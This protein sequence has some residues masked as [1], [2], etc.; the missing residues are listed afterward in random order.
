MGLATPNSELDHAA[1]LD[2]VEALPKP[3]HGRA[4]PPERRC[5]AREI[6]Q[7]LAEHGFLAEKE[8]EE[9]TKGMGASHALHEKFR[10]PDQAIWYLSG[11]ILPNST[12]I[13]GLFFLYDKTSAS[14]ITAELKGN[15]R[16]SLWFCGHE[17]T[18][19]TIPLPPPQLDPKFLWVTVERLFSEML[20]TIGI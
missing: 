12:Q 16:V 11:L 7:L 10:G 3:D 2:L 18:R 14:Q 8:L 15:P 20:S 5:S 4:L 9:A 6:A 19:L 1:V 17:T 13:A